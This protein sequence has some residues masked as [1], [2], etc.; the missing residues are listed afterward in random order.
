M[1]RKVWEFS[2]DMNQLEKD[3]DNLTQ[4]ALDFDRLLRDNLG[5]LGI[6]VDEIAKVDGRV[7]ESLAEIQALSD[8]LEKNQALLSGTVSLGGNILDVLT[9]ARV[10]S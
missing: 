1:Y 9:G 5:P 10:K 4:T 6:L 7:A 8:R 3:I 2:R